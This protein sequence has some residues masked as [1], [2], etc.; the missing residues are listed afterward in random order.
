M[1]S[2]WLPQTG[3]QHFTESRE[4]RWKSR[5]VLVLEL[6]L[7]VSCV[8]SSAICTCR[9]ANIRVLSKVGGAGGEN[10]PWL[11]VEHGQCRRGCFWGRRMLGV[12]G[13]SECHSAFSISAWSSPFYPQWPW[14]WLSHFISFEGLG[15]L[16]LDRF[17]CR[18]QS[19][20]LYSFCHGNCYC[21][22]PG[23]WAELAIINCKTSQSTAL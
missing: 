1:L 12:L 10:I 7:W 16:A 6:L 8:F 2:P 3:N 5:D 22:W 18:G 11:W 19:W 23:I 4:C 20:T 14:A 17:W 21:K 9:T 13:I 15:W